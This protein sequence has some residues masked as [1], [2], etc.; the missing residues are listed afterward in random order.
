L[1]AGLIGHE[2]APSANS[3]R[4]Q[5]RLNLFYYWIAVNELD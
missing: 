2:G 5:V 3:F 4:W 1:G